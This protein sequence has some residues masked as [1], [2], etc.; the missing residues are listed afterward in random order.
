V[1]EP[2]GT[3]PT[4]AEWAERAEHL[5]TIGRISDAE[6]AARAALAENP[7]DPG[8]LGTLAAVLLSAERYEEGLA[9]ADAA[10]AAG[11]EDERAHRL[12]ALH[13]MAMG[14]HGEAMQAAYVCVTLLPEEPAAAS[15][16]A[17]TLQAAGRTGEALQV[18]H[19]VV[20]LAPNSSGAHL[21]LADIASDLPDPRSLATARAAYEE[22]LRLDPENAV[23]RHD[24]AVLDARNHRPA[25]ALRGLVDAGRME[26]GEP[27]IL[28]TVAA[29]V[30]QLTWRL[31]IWLIVATVGTLAA[32][33]SAVDTRIAGGTVLL[34]SVLLAW[35][36]VRDLPRQ[37]LPVVRAAIRTDRPLAATCLALAY[38]VLVYVLIV[39]TGSGWLGVTVWVVLVG[40]GWLA[41]V[42]RLIR[43]KRR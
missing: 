12:R 4:S 9:V 20:R 40:L 21:L 19:R 39:V 43:R 35:W 7:Q 11:P 29:V 28:R 23:A 17:R 30:W 8:L 5:R 10:V 1:T 32:S 31:R 26:P 2:A 27:A 33:N 38:C 3:V 36:T 37:T 34:A 24:L 13:L 41:V 6:A 16:Y 18:A 22:T 42:I 25:Q 15:C 14:R